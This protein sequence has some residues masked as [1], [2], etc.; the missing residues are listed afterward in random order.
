MIQGEEGP[1][2]L[3]PLEEYTNQLGIRYRYPPS[4]WDGDG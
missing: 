2:W 1:G 4:D 3:I